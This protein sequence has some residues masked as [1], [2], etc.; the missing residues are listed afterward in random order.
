M[1]LFKYLAILTCLWSTLAPAITLEDDA[2]NTVVLAQPAQRIV[3]LAPH[4]TE[5]L[6]SAGAGDRIVG[7][8]SYSDYPDAAKTIPLVGS[9]NQVNFEQILALRPDIII[10]WE[11]GNNSDTL[12]KLAT[13]NL[14]VY[15][16]EPK[17]LQTIGRNIRQF[18]ILAGTETAANAAADAF[19]QQRQTLQQAN[20]GKPVVTLFYQVWEEPLYTLGGGHFSR[21]MYELCGGRNIFADLE[22]P[23][24]VVTLEAIVTRNPQV[25]L[26]GNHHGKRKIEEWKAK[27]ARWQSID[28]VKNDQLYLVD[29][30]IY[31]RS[32]PRAILGAAHLCEL[33]DRA[34][35]IY[36]SEAGSGA[37]SSQPPP[38]HDN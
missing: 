19:E 30:D 14:P 11:S 17:D 4:V 28:A 36:Y 24:P 7:T 37:E 35:R 32:S 13:L 25:M 2:G 16:S 5:V 26:T 1:S 33:L 6:F 21:D 20:A 34:R 31:T 12:E 23:S 15:L 9:Y 27:W 29:Q 18:G 22:H 38:F 8:V 3:S 10:A